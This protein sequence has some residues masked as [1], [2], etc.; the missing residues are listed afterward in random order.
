M[1]DF[2]YEKT[3]LLR[4]AEEI[5]DKTEEWYQKKYEWRK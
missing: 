3:R 4:N 1:I 5:W 2:A